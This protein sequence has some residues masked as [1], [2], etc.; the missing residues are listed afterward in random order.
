MLKLQE[1]TLPTD[2]GNFKLLAFSEKK[3]GCHLALGCRKTE[4]EYC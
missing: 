1:T 3:I 4:L 2:F